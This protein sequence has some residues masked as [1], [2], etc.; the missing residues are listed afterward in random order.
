[1]DSTK[2]GLNYQYVNYQDQV[3][4]GNTVHNKKIKF[5]L[6]NEAENRPF[7]FSIRFN[8]FR[9]FSQRSRGGGNGNN[10]GNDQRARGG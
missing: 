9:S 2:P 3:S 7:T 5:L 10:G 4:R 8:L 6:E 1:M